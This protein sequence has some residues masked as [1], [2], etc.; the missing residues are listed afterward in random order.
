[1]RLLFIRWKD[2]EVAN[3]LNT[4]D[5]G[6]SR[7]NELVVQAYGICSK[8]SNAMKSGNPHSGFYEAQTARMISVKALL[9]ASLYPSSLL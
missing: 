4:F 3:T 1:M 2:G 6:E 9:N 5:I 8:E 7:C